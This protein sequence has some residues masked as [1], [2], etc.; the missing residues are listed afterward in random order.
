MNLHFFLVEN[1][2]DYTV[3]LR[4]N[5]YKSVPSEICSKLSYR[6]ESKKQ[7]ITVTCNQQLPGKY[8]DIVAS[9]SS[10]SSETILKV[11]EIEMF[12]MFILFNFNLNHFNINVTVVIF[13]MLFRNIFN[14]NKFVHRFSIIDV[15]FVMD[16]RD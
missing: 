14:E 11:F 3:S 6:N 10:T 15:T 13:S 9:S 16:H 2:I 12:G 4:Q 5:L 1:G 8:I 7:T